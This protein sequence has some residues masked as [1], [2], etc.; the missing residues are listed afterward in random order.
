MKIF[1]KSDKSR[2]KLDVNFEQSFG[3]FVLDVLIV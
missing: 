2:I 1:K 3:G